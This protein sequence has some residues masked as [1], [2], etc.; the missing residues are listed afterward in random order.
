MINIKKSA[1]LVML[2]LLAVSLFVRALPVGAAK[3]APE[4]VSGNPTCQDLGY[5]Y[6]FR[7]DT[8]PN[9]GTYTDPATGVTIQITNNNSGDG[10]L[11]AWSATLNGDPFG[12]DA[13]TMKGGPNA[14]VYRYNPEATS[15]TNLVTPTNPNTGTPY[16]ISHVDFCF[17]FEVKVTKTAN[18]SF[19]R[20]WTWTIEKKSDTTELTLSTG[21][22]ISVAYE[23]TVSAT[24]ADSNF[25]VSGKISIY[26]PDPTYTATIDKV[27][28]DAGGVAATVTCLATTVAPRQTLECTYTAGPLPTNTFG[29]TNTATVTTSGKVGGG[30]GTAPITFG[31]TPT[32]EEDECIDVTDDNGTPSDTTDDVPLGQVCADELPKTFKYSLTVGPYDVCDD[33]TFTNTASFT[34]ND[35]QT[36]GSDDHTVTVNVPC[37]GGCTLT[38]GYWKTHSK[39]GPAPYDDTWNNVAG[40]NEDTTFFYSGQTYYQV[41]W[42]A[43]QGNPYYILAHQYIAA[44]LNIANG[45]STTPEVTAAITWA[46]N[47]FKTYTPSSSL[48]KAVANDAKKYA[49]TLDNYNNGLIGPGHCSE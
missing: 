10:T 43:P 2:A 31:N 14:N 26:N 48:P 40:F 6:G 24:S 20:N 45:A 22:E 8:D 13:V 28:D 4:F 12:I 3:V 29:N 23:V 38:Q 32:N 17:D 25:A 41:L 36:T 35:T 47:F 21:Q 34:T 37:G 16:G 30:S 39:Y 9:S 46:E 11:D 7:I 42:T 44:K 1:F 15:D 49:T 19:D 33:Y 5:L 18:T 27:V